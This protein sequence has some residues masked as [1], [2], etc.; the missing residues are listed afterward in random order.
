MSQR[1]SGYERQERDV[2]ETPSWVTEV[3][4][5]H[6]NGHSH[7]W[8]PAAGNGKMVDVLRRHGIEVTATDIATGDDFLEARTLPDSRITAVITNPP[9]VSAQK[10]IEH[11]LRLTAPVR[12]VVAMLLRIDYDSAKTRQ[13]LFGGCRQLKAKVVLTKRI[14]WFEDS[15]GSPSFN[16]CWMIWDWQHNGSP[17]LA[18]E[19]I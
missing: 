8:E 9:Y 13:H 3:V 15:R 10:F 4:I 5:R 6:I 1:D 11:A 19:T 16:H 2:Y 17:V 7:L 14:V 18:Y 12:G